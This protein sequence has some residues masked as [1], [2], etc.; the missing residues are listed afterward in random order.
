MRPLLC[1][2]LVLAF[3]ARALPARIAVPPLALTGVERDDAEKLEAS[4]DVKLARLQSVHLA[5]SMR[6]SEALQGMSD[7][8]CAEHDECLRGLAERTDSLYALQAGLM[9]D[10]L[11]TRLVASAR[12]VR[13]DGAVVRTVERAAALAS[14]HDTVRVGRELL[15]QLIGA[16]ELGLLLDTVPVASAHPLAPQLSVSAGATGEAS[17][18]RTVV[19]AGLMGAGTL[20]LG[21]GVT[22]AALAATGRQQL[23]VDARGNVPAGQAAAAAR[24]AHD[25]QAA[26]LLVP[27]GLAVAAGGVLLALLPSQPQVS[28]SA[29]SSG[30][31]L[32][33]SGTFP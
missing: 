16:L 23:H 17:T 6:V 28:A 22:L 25:A 5:G 31:Q 19:S 24:V 9:A 10:A 32:A 33:V 21:A 11:R 18:R 8:S 12:V 20:S 26:T 7:A 14:P 1:A 13:V 27:L 30:G 29:C 4:F 2:T 3:E 15:D